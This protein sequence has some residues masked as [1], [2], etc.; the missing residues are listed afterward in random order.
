MT[1]VDSFKVE[2]GHCLLFG[3]MMAEMMEGN[4]GVFIG[5]LRG[6]VED[7]CGFKILQQLEKRGGLDGVR[8]PYSKIKGIISKFITQSGVESGV[9]VFMTQIKERFPNVILN[10]LTLAVEYG[11]QYR[12]QRVSDLYCWRIR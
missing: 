6:I 3:Q 8:I 9:E 10:V 5:E 11:V 7:E 4:V 1:S 2:N 12:V